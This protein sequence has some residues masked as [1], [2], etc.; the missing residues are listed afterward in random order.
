MSLT[1]GT[2]YVINYNI[3]NVPNSEISDF[4]MVRLQRDGGEWET[5]IESM[6]NAGSFEWL[7]TSPAAD[8]A[9]FEISCLDN[10]TGL[11]DSDRS[12]VGDPFE[13]ELGDGGGSMSSRHFT[14]LSQVMAKLQATFG[15]KESTLAASDAAEVMEGSK[16]SFTPNAAAVKLL[17]AG[18]SQ[19]PSVIG[20]SIGDLTLVY[21]MR[22]GGVAD[23][24]GQWDIPLQCCG[25]SKT[26]STA[27]IYTFAPSSLQS[28][29]KD[30]TIEGFSGNRDT[31]KSFK[32]VIYNC[33]F[34][35]KITLDFKAE[36]P[37]AKI[38]FTGKGVY[39]AAASLATQYTIT[40]SVASILALKGLTINVFGDTDYDLCLFELDGG[41]E[42]V[43][44]MLKPTDSHGLG[45]M[46]IKQM[47]PK[48][49]LVAYKDSDTVPETTYHAGT[50]GTLSLS[51]GACPNKTTIASGAS[52]AQITGIQDGDQD[53]AETVELSGIFLD[54]SLSIVVDT[55]AAA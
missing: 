21:P 3:N 37:I 13:I 27:N 31:A 28:V 30:C 55:N 33:M 34:N 25:Y 36:E 7:V 51:W 35:Y 12:F 48:W 49:R 1:I 50:A 29:W 52:K 2:T 10:L 17:G 42:V 14:A 44:P 41:V 6:Q 54:N 39:D 46:G 53:G 8:S 23:S 15:T 40:K 47:L 18:F 24:V 38:E 45:Y 22:T 16:F 20:P 26:E 32:R 9:V 5:I 19:N 43:G 11:R 4:I